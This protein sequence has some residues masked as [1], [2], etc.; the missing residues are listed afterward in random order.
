MARALSYVYAALRST[1]SMSP[2]FSPSKGSGWSGSVVK[3]FEKARFLEPQTAA[4]GTK[5][6]S[7][8]VEE[9]D[10]AIRINV[11]IDCPAGILPGRK[12]DPL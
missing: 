9:E 12:S 8:V 2:S 6:V 5:F 1:K 4:R 11:G 7:N 10:R 3:L